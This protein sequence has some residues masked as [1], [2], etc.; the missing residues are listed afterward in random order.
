MAAVPRRGG[1]DGGGDLSRLR[2]GWQMSHESLPS[3]GDD[4][5]GAAG[6]RLRR[7]ASSMPRYWAHFTNRHWR[8]RASSS[9]VALTRGLPAARRGRCSAALSRRR[10]APGRGRRLATA[11]RLK[12]SRQQP[13]FLR[14]SRAA[15]RDTFGLPPAATGV[16][17]ELFAGGESAGGPVRGGRVG[18][19]PDSPPCR[20]R[21]PNRARPPWPL[22]LKDAGS[23]AGRRRRGRGCVEAAAD[24]NRP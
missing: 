24:G 17:P 11:T 6:P 23:C 9:S 20:S 5:R 15:G 3:R 1:G 8:R 16:E 18:R 10:V 4:P 19:R 2:S 14:L 22:A 12:G 13:G 7:P 21:D